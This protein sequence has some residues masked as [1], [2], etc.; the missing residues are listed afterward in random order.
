VLTITTLSAHN[1][2]PMTGDGNNTYLLSDDDGATCLVDAGV[3][4]PRHIGELQEAVEEVRLGTENVRLKPDSTDRLD[5]LV[6]HGHPDHASGAPAIARAFAHVRFA[7]YPWAEEDARWNVTWLALKDDE[8]IALGR[9]TLRVVFTPG[10][11]PDHVAFWHEPTAT[12]FVGD[13]VLPGGSV[14]IH[15]SRG[16]NLIQY[17]S[18][19][20][21]IRAL[22]PR[23]LLPAHGPEIDDPDLVLSTHLRHRR[24]REKQVIDALAAGHDTVQS[25]ADSIYHGLA[26]ALMP[27]AR[28]TIRA[29]LEKLRHEGRAVEDH[30]TWR[31]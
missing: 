30:D 22:A 31:L 1:P 11:S 18:S 14:M 4:D 25:I 6:T 19:L 10:H 13:L 29:H 5:V 12:V 23:R 17:L 8:E 21:R 27:A 7:K 16:G 2:G 20:E 15:T 3:G 9:E 26:V 24:M 28:E